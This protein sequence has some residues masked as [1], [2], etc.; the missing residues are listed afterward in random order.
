MEEAFVGSAV[1]KP[2]VGALG[3][4][5]ISGAS[6][7]LGPSI[8]G[9]FTD[10]QFVALPKAPIADPAQIQQGTKAFEEL[11]RG[12]VTEIRPHGSFDFP[13]LAAKRGDRTL[14]Q[15]GASQ[16]LPPNTIRGATQDDEP[17]PAP[18]PRAS[19][20]AKPAPTR[21][22][23]ES[24]LERT[25]AYRTE[26]TDRI[27]GIRQQDLAR[28]AELLG[29]ED[30]VKVTPP[31][32]PH[33]SVTTFDVEG[34][35]QREARQGTYSLPPE[36]YVQT[37]KVIF[38]P[39]AGEIRATGTGTGVKPAV[40]E[41]RTEFLSQILAE[42][43][44]RYTLSDG[45][46]E[47]QMVRRESY[48]VYTLPGSNKLVFVNN[49]S[50]NATFIVHGSTDRDRYAAMTKSELRAL[51]K[52]EVTV[53]DFR[54]E[55]SWKEQVRSAL[56][57]SNGGVTT[58]TGE[59][60]RIVKP[61]EYA[62]EG[63]A[64]K[65]QLRIMLG[66]S[67]AMIS[68]EVEKERAV[69]P[70]EFVT[71]R[72]EKGLAEHMSPEAAKR[73]IAAIE[74]RPGPAPEGHF[75]LRQMTRRTGR[76]ASLI[77]AIAETHRSAHPEWFQDFEGA[78]KKI[79]EHY[80]PEL[81]AKIDETIRARPSMRPEGWRTLE[82]MATAMGFGTSR[83]AETAAPYL[84][85][86]PEWVKPFESPQRRIET[87]YSPE[88]QEVIVGALAKLPSAPPPGARTATSFG[89][90]SGA[91]QNWISRN[92]EPYRKTNPEWFNPYLNSDSIER[93]YMEAPLVQILR[94][95]YDSLPRQKDG[96]SS[97]TSFAAQQGANKA[98]VTKLA[99]PHLKVHPEWEQEMRTPTGVPASS[100]SPELQQLIKAELNAL[101]SK[102][103]QGWKTGHSFAKEIGHTP[104][105]VEHAAE[106]YRLAHPE[107][108]RD[109]R[110]ESGSVREHYDPA[111]QAI[112][113][114]E[115]K[116]Q[117]LRPDGWKTL[118]EIRVEL[119]RSSE[120]VERLLAQ[121]VSRHPEWKK[122]YL[123]ERGQF[124]EHYS[125]EAQREIR[126]ALKQ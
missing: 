49:E 22:T 92:A 87:Y 43:G 85:D 109:H 80:A 50:N 2:I 69:H 6:G 99:A 115:L 93:E 79:E 36:A 103:P 96:W 52:S 107:W 73:I 122:S 35:V 84:K 41:N 65:S 94:S 55:P 63:W 39:G 62:P 42:R 26:V 11:T 47:P 112:L 81:V 64:T 9:Y 110:N 31:R 19:D 70:E 23:E 120:L 40:L 57:Q 28:V 53:I 32:G 56:N 98:R 71:Y 16:S 18:E 83:I 15:P 82:E 10:G 61:N 58:S 51:P 119:G 75:T 7:L 29:A 12:T 54:D 74:S 78:T 60:Q 106:T 125:P 48:Q 1:V 17:K 104:F 46:V 24:S 126:D 124:H 25:R 72:Y 100:Y 27:R 95:R 116:D 66:R 117:V 59:P 20:D 3:G 8:G 5:A 113:K 45:V 13:E 121:Q 34:F 37:N 67:D 38:P 89:A 21:S 111:L 68:R 91:S 105:V 88:F 97:V 77:S 30:F 114:A 118:R 76:D 123:T 108:F 44:E 102:A 86:H 14:P 90:E 33:G 4:L 101:P